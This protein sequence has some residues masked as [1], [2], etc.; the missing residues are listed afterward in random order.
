LSTPKLLLIEPPFYRLFKDTYALVKYPLSLGYLAAAVK[1]K[2]RWEVRVYNADFAPTSDPFEVT[3]FKDRGFRQYLN[4]LHDISGNIWREIREVVSS[5]EPTVVG[6]S[7]KSANFA[8]AVQVAHIVKAVSPRIRVVVGGPHPTTVREAVLDAASIDMAVM[9]EGEETLVELLSAIETGK[10]IGGVRGLI[11]RDGA[12]P[13]A[14]PSRP[15]MTD[16]DSLPFPHAFA[17]EV[18]QDFADYP[19]RAFSGI[20]S[21]RGCPFNCL[22]C[23]SKNIWG[24]K[25]RFRSPENVAAEMLRLREMGVEHIHFEDDTFGV[26][27]AY[28]RAICE[29]IRRQCPGISWS[30]ELH[31]RLVSEENIALMKAAGCRM[32]QLGFESGNDEILKTIRKGFTVSEALRACRIIDHQGVQ[33]QTFFMGGFPQETGESLTDTLRVIESLSCHKVIYS[34]FTPYPGT[35][36]FDLC[37]KMGLIPDGYDPSLYNHQSP[38]NLFCQALSAESFLEI[39]SRIESVVVIKNRLGRNRCAGAG[40]IVC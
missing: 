4:S 27:P 9:G 18:L 24:R 22:F 33:L 16:L 36:A 26:T 13:V 1:T 25:T 40:Q 12:Q 28:L 29:A 5:F 11:Y 8:S 23:G 3:Y 2:T 19:P 34:I 6:I 37:L 30:C 20:F 15:F 31:V 32:I 17:R 35:E 10:E 39:S 21:T 7:A 38:R 14:T